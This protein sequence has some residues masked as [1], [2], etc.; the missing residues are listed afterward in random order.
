MIQ[1]KINI[2][3]L[4]EGGLTV[5]FTVKQIPGARV[6]E[7]LPTSPAL[8]LGHRQKWSLHPIMWVPQTLHH[9]PSVCDCPLCIALA[10]SND[11]WIHSYP[12]Y[13]TYLPCPAPHHC[14]PGCIRPHHAPLIPTLPLSCLLSSKVHQTGLLYLRGCLCKCPSSQESLCACDS[15]FQPLMSP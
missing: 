3:S 8:H 15:P 7:L 9:G 11:P 5:S 13:P 14:T 2:A 1:T 6:V 12:C 10:T 4:E